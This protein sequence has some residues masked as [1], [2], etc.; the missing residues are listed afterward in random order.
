MGDYDNTLG[1]LSGREIPQYRDMFLGSSESGPA[2]QVAGLKRAAAE[3]AEAL[4]MAVIAQQECPDDLVQFGKNHGIPLFAE[5]TWHSGFEA[6]VRWAMLHS[7][8]NEE[9]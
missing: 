2:A 4:A 6:G 8:Q 5:M 7:L 1:Y 3:R 9:K